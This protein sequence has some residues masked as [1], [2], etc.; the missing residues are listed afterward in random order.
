MSGLSQWNEVLAQVNL[1]SWELAKLQRMLLILPVSAPA[2]VVEK[3]EVEMKEKT[4]DG[5]K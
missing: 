5:D 3:Q 2:K 4:M 1:V